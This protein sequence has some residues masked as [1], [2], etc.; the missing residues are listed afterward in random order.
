MKIAIINQPLANRGDESAHKAFVRVLANNLPNDQIDV[1]FLRADKALV[2]EIKVSAT[3]VNYIILPKYYLIDS[4]QKYSLLFHMPLLALLHPGLRKY[5]KLLNK[6]DK[7]ICAPGGI[8]MGGFMEWGHIWKLLIAKKLQKP[9]YYWG[10]SIGPFNDDTYQKK[11]FKKYS[12]ELLKYFS[13]ISLRDSKSISIAK[14]ICV[15][16]DEVVDSAFL[17]T[18]SAKIP[19]EI[20]SELSEKQYIVFVPNELTWHY[21]YRNVSKQCINDFYIRLI[22]LLTSKYP[23]LKIV[24]LPQTYK[25]VIND[26]N[27]FI[28]LKEML[29]NKNIIVVDEN[30]NSDIQQVIISKARFVIGARYHSIVFAINNNIPFISLSYEHKMKGLL[31]K[32]Q[33]TDAMV[34][35]QDIFDDKEY[36]KIN[37]VINKCNMIMDNNLRKPDGKKAREIVT[38]GL[39]NLIKK[40][41]M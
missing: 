6:Y 30:Q 29:N 27:Y 12:Y 11:V 33:L 28:S 37:T 38:Q 40:L 9:I 2:D 7:V 19:D 34:E 5:K 4:V 32:L 17:M 13:Y 36:D 22:G 21:R 14:E 16:V 26:Y 8:C 1:L 31:E 35:I 3:N 25:S 10:R 20:V 24:M 15:N 39:N 23:D 41:L 18:P